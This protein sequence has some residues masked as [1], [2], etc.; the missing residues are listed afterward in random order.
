MPA[1]LAGGTWQPTAAGLLNL[2]LAL[3]MGVL[4]LRHPHAIRRTLTMHVLPGFAAGLAVI[5]WFAYVWASAEAMTGGNWDTSS[6][7]LADIGLVLTQSHYGH[8]QWVSAVGVLLLCGGAWRWYD[9]RR[10]QTQTPSIADDPRDRHRRQEHREERLARAIYAAGVIVLAI[11]R[12]GTGHA[13][14]ATLPGVAIAIHSLHV[15]AAAGWTGALLVAGCAIPR[16]AHWPVGARAAYGERLSSVATTAMLVALITGAFNAWRTLGENPSQ[17]FAPEAAPYLAWLIV[18]LVLVAIAALLGAY[19]RWHFL[20]R[21]ALD[22]GDRH[23]DT[24][25][26]G[27]VIG[28]EALVLVLVMTFAAKLG[29]SMPPGM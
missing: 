2:A 28:I 21:L 15:L 3:A 23:A 1:D 11:S 18:K 17:W 29:T 22:T 5:A 12:A 7:M 25:A 14:D 8:M 9:V 27:R 16:W 4:V 26:F 10:R 24:S 19:N 6:A 13:A 20:P